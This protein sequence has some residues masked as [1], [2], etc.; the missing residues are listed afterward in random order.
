M[1]R[2][3]LLAIKDIVAGI[4]A[5]L[6]WPRRERSGLAEKQVAQHP[7]RVADIEQP[8][9]GGVEGIFAG[10]RRTHEQVKENGQPIRNV[11][12]GVEVA[13]SSNKEIVPVGN[14][15]AI[16]TTTAREEEI[17]MTI[18][19]GVKR[20]DIETVANHIHGEYQS[21]LV[22]KGTVT[23]VQE[24]AIQRVHPHPAEVIQVG[25]YYIKV[26]VVVDVN[27]VPVKRMVLVDRIALV[28]C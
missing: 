26:A 4:G 21:G 18:A 28:R 13:V 11:H 10:N 27:K 7:E 20:L 8:V 14:Q 22:G 5:T 17:L 19:V 24:D 12:L 16:H 3:K 2:R 23:G 25:G 6:E 9:V 15:Q 1:T